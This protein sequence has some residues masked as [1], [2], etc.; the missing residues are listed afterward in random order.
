M[1]KYWTLIILSISLAACSYKHNSRKV[2]DFYPNG[3]AK[4]VII[5]TISGTDS[6]AL[7][8]IHY[9][10]TGELMMQGALK[11][12]KRHGEWKSWFTDGSLWSEG[13]F[14]NG[15]R[16]DSAISY[17]PNGKVSMRGYYHQGEL[18]GIWKTYNEYG[19]LTAEKD[20]GE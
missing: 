13:R 4:R 14:E 9:H 11:N 20:Y 16:T 3:Q 2:I 10:R 6:I 17:F 19:E 5:Y 7:E 8:E 15:L 12:G 18:K 1:S